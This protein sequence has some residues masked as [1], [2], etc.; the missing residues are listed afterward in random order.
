MVRALPLEILEF[1]LSCI[2]GLPSLWVKGV[3]LF[4]SLAVFPSEKYLL[5]NALE[6]PF[7]VV[8][9]FGSSFYSQSLALSLNEKGKSRS[10]IAS[11]YT[12][13]ILM[14][15]HFARNLQ[16][17]ALDYLQGAYQTDPAPRR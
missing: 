2:K 12:P 6:R 5:R 1:L 17:Y 3:I 7:Q 8:N 16:R 11:V 9:E 14:A 10:Q 4:L 13:L 15:S